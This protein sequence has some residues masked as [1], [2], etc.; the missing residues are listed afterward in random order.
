MW[1]LCT[2]ETYICIISLYTPSAQ[3]YKLTLD[4]I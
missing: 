4:Y 2:Y 1:Q 3:I